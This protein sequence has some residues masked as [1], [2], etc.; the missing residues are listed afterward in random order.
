MG[1]YGVGDNVVAPSQANL[2]AK[3]APISRVRMM[4]GSRHF[5]MLD[6]PQAFNAHLAEFLSFKFAAFN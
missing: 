5:P 6:E 4:P 3:S 2:I 1:I